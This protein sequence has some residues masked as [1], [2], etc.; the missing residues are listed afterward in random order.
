MFAFIFKRFR[1]PIP[2]EQFKI[3]I[4]AHSTF[5]DLHHAIFWDNKFKHFQAGTPHEFID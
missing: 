3:R 2:V 5:C 1:V 4:L